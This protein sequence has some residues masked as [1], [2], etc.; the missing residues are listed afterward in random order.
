L[1]KNLRR[2]RKY[3]IFNFGILTSKSRIIII[4]REPALYS[5]VGGNGNGKFYEVVKIVNISTTGQKRLKLDY[6]KEGGYSLRQEFFKE[7][8]KVGGNLKAPPPL[9]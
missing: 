5:W 3:P 4:I 9:G 7:N 8:F 2:F 1:T 6:S